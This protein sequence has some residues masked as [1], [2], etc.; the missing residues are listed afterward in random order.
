MEGTANPKALSRERAWRVQGAAGGPLGWSSCAWTGRRAPGWNGLQETGPGNLGF[1][2]SERRAFGGSA[3][4][5]VGLL[6]GE[7]CWGPGSESR[8]LCCLSHTSQPEGPCS[9]LKLPSWGYLSVGDGD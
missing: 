5:T 9:L 8:G 2:R 6:R 3:R 1:T 7:G 4:L